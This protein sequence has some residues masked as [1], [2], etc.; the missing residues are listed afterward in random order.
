MHLAKRGLQGN[1]YP[2]LGFVYIFGKASIKFARLEKLRHYIEGILHLMSQG[3]DS[4]FG[5]RL[6]GILVLGLLIFASLLLPPQLEHMRTG[7]WEIE[8]FLA[9]LMAVPI[10]C[11]GW[12][13]PFLVAITLIPAAALLEV[14]QCL[15]PDHS[16]NFFA[17]LSSMVGVLV[18]AL[19]A[20]LIIRV[21][22][23][24]FSRR[25]NDDR[26]AEPSHTGEA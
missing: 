22:E 8:H 7:H 1:Y 23:Q 20:A 15:R 10:I 6:C 17:A 4:R 18:G 11:L 12:P 25:T 3:S 2:L 5:W 16:P 24:I 13:R 9:Y 19:V 14:L 26:R 21:L